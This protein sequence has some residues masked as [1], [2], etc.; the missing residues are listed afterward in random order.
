MVEKLMFFA[1]EQKCF[2]IARV[3]YKNGV[4]IHKCGP[5][6]GT[7]MGGC[8]PHTVR[9][10]IMDG[11]R[12][13]KRGLESLVLNLLYGTKKYDP[14]RV[15]V[16]YIPKFLGEV[17][18]YYWSEKILLRDYEYLIGAYSEGGY[19]NIE[20]FHAYTVRFQRNM[21]LKNY[22]RMF[23]FFEYTDWDMWSLFPQNA[24]PRPWVNFY[25]KSKGCENLDFPPLKQARKLGRHGL[26][27]FIIEER[28][29]ERERW[30]SILSRACRYRDLA[31]YMVDNGCKVTQEYLE[32]V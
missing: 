30:E 25:I 31:K 15:Y 18:Q 26:A 29:W 19:V 16:P 23:K 11:N 6:P 8:D 4:C 17:S 12:I 7:T 28:A 13:V 20:D 10:I 3:L 21:F 32:L 22:N 24:D 9:Q 2:D 1:L 27:M 5:E 14:S